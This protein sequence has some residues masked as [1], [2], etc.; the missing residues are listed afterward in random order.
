VEDSIGLIVKQE[1][2]A[3]EC[4][5]FHESAFHFHFHGFIE[6]TN[7]VTGWLHF[8]PSSEL[9][10]SRVADEQQ[11]SPIWAIKGDTGRLTNKHWSGTMKIVNWT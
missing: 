4:E 2:D 8:L 9:K 11:T 5:L 6:H 1:R 7:C 10:N 3:K